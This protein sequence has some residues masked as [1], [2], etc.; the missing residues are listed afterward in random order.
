MLSLFEG[1]EVAEPRTK[2]PSLDVSPDVAP[3]EVLPNG[4]LPSET[5]PLASHPT[6]DDLIIVVD[7]HS[8]IYQVFHALPAM[9]SP[10]GVEV[11]AVHGFL[12]DIANL[13]QQWKPNYLVC[14]FDESDITFR[15]EMYEQYKAHREEMPEA[16]RGQ[17]GL[18][19]DALRILG[20]PKISVSGF[21]ADDILATIA[22]RS[23][24]Y[25]SRVLLVTS[26][27]DCRQLITPKVKMLNVRKNELFGEE[28]LM[29]TWSIRPK[30]VVDFQALVGDSVDNVPGVPSIGPKAAQQ[31]L[32]QFG[33]LDAIYE[34]LERVV[35]DKKR[36]KLLEHR[37]DAYLSR[38]LVRLKDDVSLPLDWKDMRPGTP[39]PAE[40]DKLFRELGFRRLAESFLEIARV[41]NGDTN[42]V[43]KPSR[44]LN[45]DGYRIVQSLEDLQAVCREIEASSRIAIDTETTSTR[46]RDT[47]LVGVSLCWKPGQA[48]YLPILAPS[49]STCLDLDSVREHLQPLLADPNKEWIGQ[50][51]KFDAIV[52]R[53]H[54]L[55]IANIAFDTMVADYL[56]DAGGRNHDLGDIAKRWLGVESISIETLIGTGKNQKT[57]DQVPV[58]TVGVYAAEDVDIPMQCHEPM[59]E[60]LAA[61]SLLPL[62]QTLELP[63]IEVLADMEYLGVRVDTDRLEGL[64]SQ[65]ASQLELLRAQIM[66]TAGSEFNPDSPKQLATVLFERLG[67][68]VVKK[69]KTGPS[70]DAEVLEELAAEHPLPAKIIEYRQLAKLLSTYIESLPRLVSPVTGRVHT[71]YRQD[72]A[73]TGRLSS[74]EPNL[75][76]IPVRTPE[77]RSIRSAFVA[78]EP[79][80]LLMTADYSQI[81]L[82]VLAHCCGDPNLSKAFEEDIDIHTAVAAQVHRVSLDQVTS[83][84]RRNA[85]AVSFG[86]LYGQS[87]F[88][89]AKGLGISRTEASTFIDEYFERYPNVRQFIAKTLVECRAK[90]YVTT[91]SGRRRYLKG[92]RDFNALDEAKKKQLLEPERM[93]VNTVIQ[94]SAADMIKLAM[95]SVFRTLKDSTLR[96]QMLLQIHDELVFEVHPDDAQELALLVKK[97]M[98]QVMPLSVP[99][100]VDVKLGLNWSECE[101]L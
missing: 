34:N 17:I 95:I 6:A 3:P 94:G 16:L 87:P 55:P 14:A 45:A 88:G 74:V 60:R 66:E 28:E 84:M 33:S 72:I 81:E 64:R 32:D 26:D 59:Q 54:G 48:A 78:G 89:L 38:D 30:Q 93:A 76:N 46:P 35:G 49:G 86:I 57:M 92:I 85:K 23:S 99:L 2:P 43:A 25:G 1:D 62:M 29:A 10:Q 75:Q 83:S 39:D 7:S 37:A 41:T 4:T 51:M 101:P 8:L 42:T 100:K 98:T 20:I 52:L 18:I 91:M 22:H 67:L 69:T 79:G 24:E 82:R 63:L 58:E 70:T 5:Q 56:L 68:R 13:L 12:R 47:S 96:A 80:W 44:R 71:S 77:G 31:L 36:E 73:A 19:V 9:T 65:F 97:E 61:E 53:A 11:G 21:E 90:G 15:N 50:N 27:K 40:L